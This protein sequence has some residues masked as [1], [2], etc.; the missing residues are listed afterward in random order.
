MIGSQISGTCVLVDVGV[1]VFLSVAVGDGVLVSA[2]GRGALVDVGVGVFVAVAVGIG[3][4]VDVG[5]GV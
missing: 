4:L 1:G 3:V 5:V 2:P